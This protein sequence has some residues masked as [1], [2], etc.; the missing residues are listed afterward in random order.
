MYSSKTVVSKDVNKKIIT[1]N[2]E[3][4]RRSTKKEK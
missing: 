4:E 1:Y 2:L 3:N